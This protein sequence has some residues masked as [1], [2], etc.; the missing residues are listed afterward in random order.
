METIKV[1][2]NGFDSLNA[3]ECGLYVAVV[4]EYEYKS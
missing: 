4:K 2:M 3:E 1:F